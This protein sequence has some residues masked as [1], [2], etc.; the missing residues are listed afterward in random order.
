MMLFYKMVNHLVHAFKIVYVL[1]DREQ[2]I[3]DKDDEIQQLRDSIQMSPSAKYAEVARTIGEKYRSSIEEISISDN[4]YFNPRTKR[5][6]SVPTIYIKWYGGS[7][8]A[9]VRSELESWV[10]V[11]LGVEEVRIVSE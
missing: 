8:N 2:Q 10:P 3:R 5:Q 4:T 1:V 11:L 6:Q 7:G 9:V